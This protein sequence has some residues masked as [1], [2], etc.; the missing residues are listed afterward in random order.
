MLDADDHFQ[1]RIDTEIQTK[2][3]GYRA[4]LLASV[5]EEAKMLCDVCNGETYKRVENMNEALHRIDEDIKAVSEK[6][7]EEMRKVETRRTKTGVVVA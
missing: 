7:E 6:Y 2:E 5:R 1:A 3:P 4:R